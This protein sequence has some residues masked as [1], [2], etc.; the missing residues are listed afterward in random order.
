MKRRDFIWTIAEPII[1]KLFVLSCLCFFQCKNVTEK[2]K[3]SIIKS[4][5]SGFT[6]ITGYIHNRELYPNTKDIIINVSHVSGEDRVTQIKSPVNNDGT[7][8]FEIDMVRSQ[9]VTM[10][11]YLDFLYLVPGDSLHIEIDFNNLQDVRLS[12]GKSV[13]INHDFFK[14]FDA[15][16][17]RTSYFNYR[18]VGTDC[19]RNCSWAEIRKKLDEER[20]EYRDRRQA[21]LQKTSVCDEVVFLTDAMIEL[22]YYKAF[23]GITMNRE[24]IYGKETMD[25][26]LVMN[27]LN[28]VAGIYFNSDFYSNSH[29]K[30]IA[31]A[32]IPAARFTTQFGSD[33]SYRERVKETE[34]NF[35]EWAKEV[36]KTEIIKDFMLTVRAGGALV[37]RDLDDFEKYTTDIN[38]E[39]LIDRLLQEY[40]VTR[41][42]M[43]N[44]EIISAYILGNMTDFFN[45]VSFENKN[46]LANKTTQYHGK[47]QVINIGAAWCAPC[48]PVLEQF[49]VLMKEYADKDVCFSFICISGDNEGTRALYREKGIDDTNVHFATGDEWYFLQ[50]NFAPIGLPYGILVNR[51]GVIVDYGTH[52]RPSELF[53]KK[54]NLLLLQDKLMK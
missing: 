48:K 35:A 44:P 31:S 33:S 37:Q 12:G 2:D 10:E 38:N 39:Y 9:D 49:G 11:P 1:F 23:M 21:F 22:D 32:Y 46:L 34:V 26:D 45:S 27:E 40:T 36:A 8:D 3:I 51:K 16:G 20:N 43:Q 47:V 54:L 7:F 42:K 4:E 14:Y 5:S 30:F 29:F 28:E 41:M 50:S 24:F 17:Y 52:I 15:T 18:G 25:K 53:F 19:E 13:K 6:K